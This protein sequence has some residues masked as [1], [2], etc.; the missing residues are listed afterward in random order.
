M[1]TFQNFRNDMFKATCS[2]CALKIIIVIDVLA[3]CF[4]F[5]L[6][7]DLFFVLWVL[8]R[9]SRHTNSFLNGVWSSI[10][11]FRHF[12]LKMSFLVVEGFAIA[13]E[14]DRAWNFFRTYSNLFLLHI[15]WVLSVCRSADC[16]RTSLNELLLHFFRVTDFVKVLNTEAN[17]VGPLSRSLASGP[18]IQICAPVFTLSGRV[19]FFVP[20]VCEFCKKYP[21]I[22]RCR[23]WKFFSLSFLRKCF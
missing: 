4:P 10:L 16:E 20:F 9:L 8:T 18:R 15:L 5:F 22:L 11:T 3:I 1:R 12:D 7:T 13:F 2:W 23:V 6:L 21:G 17:F 14:F 19:I